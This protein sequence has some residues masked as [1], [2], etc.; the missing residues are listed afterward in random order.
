MTTSRIGRGAEAAAL[1]TQ[2]G[3]GPGRLN[4]V[5]LCVGA[6]S[7]EDLADWQARRLADRAAS[8]LPPRLAH[9]TRM[10]PKRADAL[11][12]GGSLYWVIKG[13]ILVRQRLLAIE[14]AEGVKAV[15]LVL[16]PELVSTA[17]QPRRPFQG[18]R[19]LPQA[20]APADLSRSGYGGRG[21]DDELPSGLREAVADYGVL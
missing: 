8:G 5:K 10:A 21:A 12:A 6:E 4:L 18:W 15:D 17:A 20:D 7:V 3:D 13:R 11:L 2:P 9:R 19:Y 14:P 16:G 1:S